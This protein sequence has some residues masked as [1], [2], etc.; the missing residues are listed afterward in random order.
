MRSRDLIAVG[1]GRGRRIVAC[2]LL[3]ALSAAACDSGRAVTLT[4]GGKKKD[5]RPP[6]DR[7][8]LLQEVFVFEAGVGLEPWAGVEAGP[9]EG[10]TTPDLHTKEAGLVTCDPSCQ[11]LYPYM[12]RKNSSGKCVEC[13]STSDC[14]ANPYA[15]GNSCITSIAFCTCSTS[16]DCTGSVWGHECDTP[17]MMCACISD[18]DC[19]SSTLGPRCST[20]KPDHQ[21]GCASDSDC[22]GSAFGKTCNTS[23]HVC[24]C[25]GTG[26]CPTGKTCT[27]TFGS[28]TVCK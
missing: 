23:E 25:S 15:L 20:T 1:R 22:A 12:C 21:C 10:G 27:D 3:A 14:I 19:S 26:D 28:V 7:G 24:S 9:V 11:G 17:N 4:D 18:S 16:A 8:I 13:T 2:G 5:T 6:I